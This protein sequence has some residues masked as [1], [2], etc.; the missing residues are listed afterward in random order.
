MPD[1]PVPPTSS[2]RHRQT[3]PL[4]SGRWRARS[5]SPRSSTTPTTLAGP[6]QQVMLSFR[7]RELDPLRVLRTTDPL[8]CSA[9]PTAFERALRYTPCSTTR[10]VD[11][12]GVVAIST[13][14]RLAIHELVAFH[15]HLM[16][17]G[18]LDRL[19]ELFTEDV[20][21]DLSPLGGSVLRGVSAIR[22]AAEQLGDRNPVAAP[23]TNT[24]VSLEDGDVTARSKFSWVFNGTAR[25][26]VEP[27]TTYC[28]H[29]RR[30]ANQQPA[31]ISAT[32]APTP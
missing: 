14:D 32:R 4:D 13:Q 29:L 2:G 23:T 16:D 7:V 12:H 27:L 17:D 8:C 24:V 10:P 31:G 30:L 1:R 28:A 20:T 25:L 3:R 18:R 22:H 9:R 6:D 15:G 26:A 5:G 19:S 21:Y 11:H